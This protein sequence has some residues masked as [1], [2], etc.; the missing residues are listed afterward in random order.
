[1]AEKLVQNPQ[2]IEWK[3]GICKKVEK[4]LQIPKTATENVLNENFSEDLYKCKRLSA[5]FEAILP[6]CDNYIDTTDDNIKEKVFEVFFQKLDYD[7]FGDERLVDSENRL[8]E[9]FMQAVGFNI[10]PYKLIYC[11]V[12]TDAGVA[13][14]QNN[15]KFYDRTREFKNIYY[16][17]QEL[18]TPSAEEYENLDAYSSL[19]DEEK[20]CYKKQLADLAKNDA[21]NV[22]EKCSSIVSKSNTY[23]IR[24]VYEEI[25]SWT[26]T[27]PTANGEKCYYMFSKD[28]I[29]SILRN[30]PSLFCSS[31]QTISDA[32]FYL[33]K[34]I[35]TSD[36]SN[37]KAVHV[38]RYWIKNNSSLL[39]MNA[40]AMNRKQSKI[41]S[42]LG[43]NYKRN[44]KKMFYNKVNLGIISS[45]PEPKII[46]NANNN[47]LILE[48]L[49]QD[50]EAV[51][52]YIEKNI[53]VLG[54]DSEKF[55]RLLNRLCEEDKLNPDEN[56]LEKFLELGRRL[57]VGSVDFEVEDI[58][59]K[60][61]ENVASEEINLELLSDQACL[62]KFLDIFFENNQEIR[63]K[64]SKLMIDKNQRN[65][66]GEGVL[67]RRMR[68]LGKSME[69]AP[70]IL[71]AGTVGA[72]Q[73]VLKLGEMIDQIAQFRYSLVANEILKT[74]IGKNAILTGDDNLIMRAVKEKEVEYAEEIEACLN[75][76]REQYNKNQKRAKKKY[77]CIDELFDR[78]M[79]YLDRCFDD[80]IAM[81]Q[82]YKQVI[83][84]PFTNL[85][86]ESFETRKPDQISIFNDEFEIMISD[87]KMRQNMKK[88]RKTISNSDKSISNLV[89]KNPKDITK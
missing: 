36:L 33:Y 58:V 73:R 63:P 64:L 49:L 54:F 40:A 5:M 79:T 13:R 48:D 17:L 42:I 4:Y 20:A 74:D 57:F 89:I 16:R 14:D 77:D 68:E 59:K 41:F 24:M 9:I 29:R 51:S 10:N 55:S 82:L 15:H 35:K 32:F 83:V 22:I 3:D 38:L 84:E 76:I 85:L 1:M 8:D 87:D 72:N 45:I 26:W 21:T 27:M 70:A 11:Q 28:E 53:L 52:D 30:N 65:E 46:K 2:W 34:K 19:D 81:P 67:R 88:I 23:K 86:K 43:E 69:R 75:E 80:K 44:F 62:N 60:V 7:Q 71:K 37:E 25:R 47:I 31:P 56:N 6:Y 39:S 18:L 12:L 50:R 66:Q 61:K 78:T